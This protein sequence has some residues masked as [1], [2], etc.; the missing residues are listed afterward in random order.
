MKVFPHLVN[1]AVLECQRR[2]AEVVV[3][4]N[5]HSVL[6]SSPNHPSLPFSPWKNLSSM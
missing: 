1:Y 3:V 5:K 4:N 2:V 6:E